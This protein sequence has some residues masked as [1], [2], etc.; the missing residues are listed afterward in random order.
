MKY[1]TFNGFQ[2]PVNR[3]ALLLDPPVAGYFTIKREGGWSL[4][5]IGNPMQGVPPSG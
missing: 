5:V 3:E 1:A 4:I 2:F